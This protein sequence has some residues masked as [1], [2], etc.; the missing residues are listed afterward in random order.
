MKKQVVL[1]S[2][3]AMALLAAC[4]TES[5]VT[6][7][8]E[9]AKTKGNITLA[10]VDG[11]SNKALD[12]AE[13]RSQFD[14]KTMYSDDAGFVVYKQKEI[15]GY[16][17]DVTK[18]DYATSRVYVS[19]VETGANDVSRVPN[20]VQNVPLYK[21]DVKV[22]GKVYY[23]DAKTGN[24]IPAPKVKVVLSYGYTG[25]SVDEDGSYSLAASKAVS[26]VNI[27]PSEL[28][29]VTDSSGKYEF[30]NVAEMVGFTVDVLQSKI[31]SKLFSSTGA[32]GASAV[33]SGSKIMKNI[34]MNVDGEVPVL[35]GSNLDKIEQSSSLQFDFSM[36]LVADSLDGKWEVYKN[37]SRVLTTVSLSKDKRS[38]I[39]KPLSESWSTKTSYTVKGVVYTKEGMFTN[40]G[41][42][43]FSVGSVDVPKSV[44]DLK[45]KLDTSN[46][47]SSYGDRYNYEY[48]ALLKLT[49]KAPSGGV[50]GYNI[51]YMTSEM[52]DF[53]YYAEVDTNIFSRSISSMYFLNDTSVV[54]VSFVVLPYNAAGE[55]SVKE[56]KSVKWNVPEIKDDEDEDEDDDEED[57][58][59]GEDSEDEESEFE[60]DDE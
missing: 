52:D 39:V 50:D 54:S 5:T 9:D 26:N 22:S 4:S 53:E 12:S 33:R 19:V 30:D 58:G 29:D 46:Y 18:E 3:A 7:A 10:I 40:V 2:T 59:D 11:N 32:V 27:Y 31:D 34:V 56:A 42:L 38:V 47:I 8:F 25:S 1:L 17:F 35:I 51:Y 48:N 55:A 16:V 60:E 57:D 13:V 45:V 15:G 24:L 37:G 41:N 44:S 23:R 36:D 21:A 28:T 49:W 20:V 14:D 6:T 43:S